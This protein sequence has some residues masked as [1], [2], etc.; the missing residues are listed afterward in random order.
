[1]E[2]KG[3]IAFV[4]TLPKIW[5]EWFLIGV[6]AVFWIMV[7]LWAEEWEWLRGDNRALTIYGIYGLII[8]G[9]CSYRLKRWIIRIGMDPTGL[10]YRKFYSIRPKHRN[11]ENLI[12]V[13]RQ[14]KGR[15][16]FKVYSKYC[17]FLG[18]FYLDQKPA[19]EFQKTVKDG[20]GEWVED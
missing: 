19:A 10:T 15:Q 6:Y 20:G 13:H 1:M 2:V 18:R 5:F 17:D 7:I 8:L 14:K 12:I 4:S 11:Y 3:N 9:F 16:L